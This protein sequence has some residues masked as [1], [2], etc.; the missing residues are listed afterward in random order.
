LTPRLSAVDFDIGDEFG[1]KVGIELKFSSVSTIREQ[2][3]NRPDYL[4]WLVQK[5]WCF[6]QRNQAVLNWIGGNKYHPDPDDFWSPRKTIFRTINHIKLDFQP[7]K[8]PRAKAYLE[9]T[10]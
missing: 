6:P 2:Q 7:G 1:V 4:E 10:V 3:Q 5:G 8:Q 9:Y